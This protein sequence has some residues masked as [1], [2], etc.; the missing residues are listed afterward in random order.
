MMMLPPVI[1]IRQLDG[2]SGGGC[3]RRMARLYIEEDKSAQAS[4]WMFFGKGK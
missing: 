4:W 1:S 2:S 3:D